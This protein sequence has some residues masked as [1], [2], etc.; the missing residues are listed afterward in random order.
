MGRHAFAGL[1]NQHRTEASQIE[2]A[3]TLVSTGK[4]R[5][6]VGGS[7]AV[8]VSVVGDSSMSF[9]QC[10][11]IRNATEVE[12]VWTTALEVQGDGLHAYRGGAVGLVFLLDPGAVLWAF[13]I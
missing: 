1:H 3:P 6:T 11:P 7:G 12:V 4:L 13:H 8:R 2:I 5:V 9:H 10:T